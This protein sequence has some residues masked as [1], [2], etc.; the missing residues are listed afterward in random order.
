MLESVEDIEKV[1]LGR[2]IDLHV[3][4]LRLRQEQPT[5]FGLSLLTSNGVNNVFKE[6]FQHFSIFDLI[7]KEALHFHPENV[8]LVTIHNLILQALYQTNLDCPL[9]SGSPFYCGSAGLEA[10]KLCVFVKDSANIAECF[11]DVFERECGLRR[12]QVE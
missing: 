5:L 4:A 3:R 9:K 12:S 11:L 10:N 2:A 1:R 7:S 6:C 8:D